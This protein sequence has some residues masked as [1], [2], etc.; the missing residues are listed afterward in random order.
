MA[1]ASHLFRFVLLFTSN[2]SADLDRNAS[3]I[4]YHL[5]SRLTLLFV[6]LFATHQVDNDKLVCSLFSP[7]PS[8][9]GDAEQMASQMLSQVTF[10][11]PDFILVRGVFV[12]PNFHPYLF[13]C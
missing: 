11:K 13:Y 1:V 3:Q 4:G 6:E 5:V 7:S 2:T 10:L 8:A 9:V 12:F